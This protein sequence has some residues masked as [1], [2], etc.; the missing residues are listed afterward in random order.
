MT[1]LAEQAELRERQFFEVALANA[2]RCHLA[3]P[4]RCVRCTGPND[5]RVDGFAVCT[6]CMEESTDGD[7]R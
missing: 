4:H 7:P 2:S 5:R 6:T 3:G 1:D